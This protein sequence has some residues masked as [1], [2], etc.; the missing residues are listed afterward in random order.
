MSVPDGQPR[1]PDEEYSRR[2]RQVQALMDRLKLDLVLAYGDD[3]AVFGP[4]HVRWLANVPVHF[5]PML[6]L[7][8]AAGEPLLLCGPE[9]DR[10]ALQVGRVRQVRVLREFTHPDEDYP[11]SH[12]L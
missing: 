11:Y 2:W 7:V 6:V 5:E 4:A 9:S 3:R 1:I 12:I 10:Y 8:R